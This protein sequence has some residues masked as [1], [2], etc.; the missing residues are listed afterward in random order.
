MNQNITLAKYLIGIGTEQIIGVLGSGDSFEIVESFIHE[1]GQFLEAPTEFSAPIIASAMNKLGQNQN[2]SVSISIRG[3]GLVSSLPGIYHN[4]IEDLKSLSISEGLNHDDSNYNYH[5]VFNAE[6]AL[7]SAGLVRSDRNDI[8]LNSDLILPF[9]FDNKNRIAHIIT[10]SD[11]LYLYNPSSDE[12]CSDQSSDIKLKY[13]KKLFVIGKRGMEYLEAN[14]ILI[15]NAPYFLTP[16]ALPYADL[17][18]PNYLGVWTGNEQ[19]KAYFLES[20]D[21]SESIIVRVG[22]MKR[23][24]LT[25]RTRIEHFDIPIYSKYTNIEMLEFFTEF[26]LADFEEEKNYL[27]NFRKKVA[28]TKDTWNV[29]TVV[30]IINDLK[31]ELNYSFDVG[32]YATIIENYIRPTKVRRLHSAF[33]GKFM[34]TAVPISIGISLAEPNIPVLCMLGE[35]SF[36][37]SFNDIASVVNLQLPV[38]IIVFS[39]GSMHSIVSSKKIDQQVKNYLLPSNY[40]ALEKMNIPNL[41]TYHVNSVKQFTS[42]LSKWDMKSPTMIFLKFDSSAYAKGVE[43]LR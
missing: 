19:F 2:R 43:L 33:I 18:S 26:E 31:I 10:R 38:C 25:L 30:S 17:N 20:K 6:N 7:S 24:L 39:D 34:G 35:G 32:S 9:K 22:V 40:Q 1:G 28:N 11:H 5:K 16:A 4:Y 41:P 15:P 36:S 14:K 8:S 27:V 13:R 29:Y 3:P 23:E 12:M 37:S 42:A 21:L